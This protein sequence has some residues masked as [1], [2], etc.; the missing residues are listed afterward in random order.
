MVKQK[1]SFERFLKSSFPPAAAIGAFTSFLGA[2]SRRPSESP[3]ESTPDSSL[4]QISF[5]EQKIPSDSKQS[6]YE[7][8]YSQELVLHNGSATKLFHRVLTGVAVDASDKIYVLGDGE[9]RIFDGTGKLIQRWK[10]PDG[11]LCLTIDSDELVYFGLA[12]Q[13]E[14]YSSRGARV[15]GFPANDSGRPASIT[16]IKTFAREILIADAS[17]RYIRRYDANGKHL[18]IIGIHGKNRGFMLPNRL[19]DMDVDAAGVI[20]STDPGRHRVSSWN[21]DGSPAAYFG[22]FGQRNPEDFVGCCNPVNLALAPDGKIVTAEKVAC[23]VKVY[24][25]QGTLLALIGAGYFDEK[26]THLPL[27]TDSKGRI[28]VADPVRLEVKVF[29]T[30]GGIST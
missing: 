9:V 8:E 20:W 27:A 4:V 30:G 21:L 6:K 10:S 2:T 5:S 19:L 23:R 26:C 1:K 7:L 25:A 11:A 14:I 15:G 24:N 13:V 3:V 16:S 29:S 22:K 17:A 18:G 12:G 28:I